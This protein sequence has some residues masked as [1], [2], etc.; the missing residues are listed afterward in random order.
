M[1]DRLG[2]VSGCVEEAISLGFD[3]LLWIKESL[4]YPQN[5]FHFSFISALDC[6]LERE[7]VRFSKS[8]CRNNAINTKRIYIILL[9]HNAYTSNLDQLAPTLFFH[10]LLLIRSSQY[11]VLES[12]LM[13]YMY[14]SK[15]LA[16]KFLNEPVTC[17]T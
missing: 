7:E 8:N 17:H 11:H 3:P 4:N 16:E 13:N 15:G 9:D 10:L 1:A 12:G 14:L 2:W 6:Y 5:L